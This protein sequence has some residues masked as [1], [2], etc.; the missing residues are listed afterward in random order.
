MSSGFEIVTAF[1]KGTPFFIVVDHTSG[2]A[3]MLELEGQ[4]ASGV[5]RWNPVHALA[6]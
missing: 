3:S 1:R 2:I 4:T 6:R 5:S